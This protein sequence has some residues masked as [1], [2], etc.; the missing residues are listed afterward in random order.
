MD[1]SSGR[2]ESFRA[3]RLKRGSSESPLFASPVPKSRV[4]MVALYFY[5][6]YSHTLLEESWVS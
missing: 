6:F 2:S 1:G 3:V 4:S 5:R